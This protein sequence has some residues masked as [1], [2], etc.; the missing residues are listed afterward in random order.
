MLPIE[1]KLLI[2]SFT[3][4]NQLLSKILYYIFRIKL[5]KDIKN[6]KNSI[7]IEKLYYQAIYEIN[8]VLPQQVMTSHRLIYFLPIKFLVNDVDISNVINIL[9][10]TEIL[11]NTDIVVNYIN[12]LLYKYGSKIKIFIY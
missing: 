2:I 7:R 4:L 11:R 10:R 9:I 6:S 12:D 1:L 8:D 5:D 3:N